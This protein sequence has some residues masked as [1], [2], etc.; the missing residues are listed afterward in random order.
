MSLVS[1]LSYFL[2][3]AHSASIPPPS[4]LMVSIQLGLVRSQTV[5][6]VRL[7]DM[8]ILALLQ[9][10]ELGFEMRHSGFRIPT[11]GHQAIPPAERG[12]SEF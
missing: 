2:S 11:T 6:I 12:L 8:T 1:F 4:S 3:G 7:N 9:S 5:G 10:E